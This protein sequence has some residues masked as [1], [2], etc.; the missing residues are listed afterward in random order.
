M[1]KRVIFRDYQEQQAE[2]HNDLQAFTRASFD[3]LVHDTIT[4]TRRYAGFTVIKSAQAEIQI[5]PGRFYDVLGAVYHRDTTLVQSVLTYLP[6]VAQ[7]KLLI[8]VF[9]NE[10][11]TDVEERD[12]L[13][14]VDT[15]R[16][17]PD[18]VSTAV[19]RDAVITITQ[20]AESSDP[21]PPAI[22][23]GHAPIAYVTLDSIQVLN[24]QMLADFQVA[25]TE[26][27]DVRTDDLEVFRDQIGP[28]VTSLASDL[29]A[30]AAQMKEKGTQFDIGML[31]R[32]LA[33]VKEKAGLPATYAQYGSDY[34]IDPY[35]SD[36][37]DTQ[38]LGY[39]ALTDMG[40]RFAAANADIFEISLF[41]ANDPNA[42]N[43]GGLVLPKYTSEQKF[44]VTAYH[45]DL[46]MAQYGYQTYNLVQ[47]KIRKERLR[48][49]GG[50][51]QCTNGV[52]LNNATGEAAPTW[53][54]DFE[55]YETVQM[56][57]PGFVGHVW[58]QFDSWWHDSW[59]ETYWE[60]ETIDHTITGAQIA[61]TFLVAN[62]MW[63]TRLSFYV[64]QKAAAENIHVTLC[65]VSNG[66]PDTGKVIL[67]QVH[68]HAGILVG[69]NTIDIMP[70]FLERG[71]R[72]AMVLTS[73]AN[74]RIGMAYGQKYL[75][76]TFFYS[77]D[78]AYYL[79]D[80]MKDMLFIVWGAKFNSSQVTIEF[81]PINLDGGLRNI[82]ITA[83]TI[84]PASCNLIYEMRPNGSGEWQ[85]LT[86]TNVTALVGAPPL[87]QFRARFIGTRDVQP[88]LL[89]T[90][91]R[92]YVSR[93]K[94]V[95]KHVSESQTLGAA[96]T[97][98]YVRCLL[99]RFDETPHDF[100]LQLSVPSSPNIVNP[101][102]TVD[103]IIDTNLKRRTRTF[104]F[105]V[106]STT[107][108][109]MV[110]NGATNSPATMYHV[111]HRVFWIA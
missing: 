71:K 31:Y 52:R 21:Q 75:D 64:T 93:P 95:F 87:C 5:A 58:N 80:L 68:A 30:L 106:P 77:T 14:D 7:R 23:V 9:G 73:N 105:T 29:A 38:L 53:L 83:G 65:E 47:R 42:S 108:F 67:Q 50:Y 20:G 25:S 110:M 70:T 69:W 85:P 91:S 84:V 49:G 55:T 11:E 39:D 40:V 17:E 46:G 28:R 102:S 45:D 92:V 33:D 37:D 22:P 63:A 109:T 94:T 35:D 59:T 34:F 48:Y 60:L 104:H 15:G 103:E 32:D 72:Y 97:S 66:M 4:K 111:A 36:I 82:D 90:G 88:G 98:I 100:T 56:T 79:G 99:E 18:A 13:V 96:A 41:S 3:H 86:P 101:D 8:S 26:D 27:L 24:V 1:E 57:G 12:F 62:D 107:T 74:H 19:S 10:N 89:L 78:G 2:D 76:G 43:S 6:A 51:T 54:P 81:A 16:T 44:G 61:Q